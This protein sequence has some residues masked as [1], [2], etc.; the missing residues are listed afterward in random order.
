MDKDYRD[1]QGIQS[2]GKNHGLTGQE[3]KKVY[4]SLRISQKDHLVLLL[5]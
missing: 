1:K 5:G 3:R 4:Y 2:K